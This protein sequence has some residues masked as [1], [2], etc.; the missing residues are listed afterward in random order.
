MTN[1]LE[2]LSIINASYQQINFYTDGSVIDIGTNQC[3]MGIGW[4]QIDN[5]NQII[6][7][8]FAKIHFWPSSYKAELMSILSAISTAPRNSTINIFTDS[9]SIIT[10]YSNIYTTLSNPN[11]LFKFNTWPIWHT[12]L[13]I[14]KSYNL[15][16]TFYKV[17]AHSDNPYNNLADLL[18]KQ[19]ISSPSLH[20]NYTNIY[21]PYHII[22]WDRH[23]IEHPTRSFIKNIC[24]AYILAMWSSQKRNQEWNNLISEIDWRSTWLY[25][26]HNQKPTHNL[27]TFKLNYLKSFKI[28]ILLN[29]LHTHFLCHKTYPH[30]F[31]NTNCFCCN[32]PDS[33]THWRLCSNPTLLTD[34][35]QNTIT[36]HINQTNLDLSKKEQD[37]LIYNIRNNEAFHQIPLYYNSFYLDIILKG[38]IPKSLVQAIQNFNIPYKLASYIIINMLLEINELCYE[39]L[40]KPYCIKFSNWKK[41]QKLKPP[42]SIPLI[43]TNYSTQPKYT[44]HNYTYFCLC[45]QPDQTHSTTN[46]CPPIGLAIRKINI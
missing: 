9:Q 17:Q 11:K 24:K 6:H 42:Y 33:S 12:L 3:T 36:K 43:Q 16:V 18:A 1:T 10:K 14:I 19:H 7:K 20:F 39:K 8:F 5:N 28:K 40:W 4:V 44:R 46:T 30:K 32:T 25:F 45:G 22:Y 34:I 15:Q 13:N 21:N 37:K 41:Q 35:I 38:L 27:T 31:C 2:Q 29:E 26:N 23:F